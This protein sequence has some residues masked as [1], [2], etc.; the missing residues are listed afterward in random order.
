M[1][2]SPAARAQMLNA[3]DETPAAPAAGISHLGLHTAYSSTGANE[4][5][6]GSYARK[7]ATWGAAVV[8]P[9][10]TKDL[11]AGV[12]FDVVAGTYAW[13]GLWNQLAAGGTFWGMLP[14]GGGARRAFNVSD[15]GDLTA[16]LIDSPTHGLS[17]GQQVVFWAAEGA[18][19]PAPLAE[20]TIYH[21]IAAGLTADAFSV[22]ATSGGS[23][24]DITAIG[25]GSFQTIVP[26]T[27]AAPGQMN[28]TGATLYLS[29]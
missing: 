13:L 17:A 16:N 21:V 6:G 11:S 28:V 7:A 14:L 19:L 27:Y 2:F 18:V 9:P 23:A 24:I 22:S 4:A 3:M 12:T 26:E 10:T 5:A 29:G 20:G 1:T 15:A 8:G 25:D